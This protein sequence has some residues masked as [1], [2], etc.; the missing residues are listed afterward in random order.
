MSL[1]TAP[2]VTTP[3]FSDAILKANL[4]RNTA[5]AARG[6]FA[7]LCRKQRATMQAIWFNPDL[8]PAEAVEAL[9]TNAA[10][11][12]IAHGYLTGA[13]MQI[14]AL[15]NTEEVT[16]TPDILLPTHAFTLNEDGTVTILDT[17]YAG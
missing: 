16:V 10:K 11:Y 15:D 9:G 12:F 5:A 6:N 3:T 17:P 13:I 7:D 8:T 14:A 2:A 1:F 4:A